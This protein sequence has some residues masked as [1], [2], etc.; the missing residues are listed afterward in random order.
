MEGKRKALSKW[1]LLRKN[2]PLTV[3]LFKN[4]LIEKYSVWDKNA[5]NG[6]Q[7]ALWLGAAS[8]LGSMLFK[9]TWPVTWLLVL[10]FVLFTGAFVLQVM[11]RI[12]AV[13]T[14]KR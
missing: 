8:L 13:R 1:K 9:Q 12:I 11:S 2:R 5:R 3:R 14:K 4:Y 6:M 10:A 7:A